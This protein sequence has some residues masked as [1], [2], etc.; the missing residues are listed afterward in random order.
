MN[1]D[2]NTCTVQEA[3][4]YAVQQM[5]KQGKPCFLPHSDGACAYADGHG[6][7]CAIGWLLNHNN[8][9]LMSA[10]DAISELVHDGINGIPQIIHKNLS[11]FEKLQQFHDSASL[12][13]LTPEMAKAN[14][15]Q[16]GIDTSAPH[17]DEWM[18]IANEA[19]N[20]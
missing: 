12:R 19:K 9:E 16:Q 5:V 14:L 4:D 17:W 11:I 2:I 8:K 15:E 3:C 13:R 10:G 20:S 1:I 18:D 7:H 6:N